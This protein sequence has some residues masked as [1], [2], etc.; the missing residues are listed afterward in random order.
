MPTLTCLTLVG[1]NSDAN[2]GQPHRSITAELVTVSIMCLG[3]IIR[4]C[5][6]LLEQPRLGEGEQEASPGLDRSTA[7]LLDQRWAT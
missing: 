5:A 4:R 7:R 2:L 6:M 3:V 1:F